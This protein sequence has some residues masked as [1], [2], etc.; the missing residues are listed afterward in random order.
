[1]YVR[2]SVRLL[3]CPSAH[4]KNSLSLKNVCSFSSLEAQ[5]D[6]KVHAITIHSRESPFIQHTSNC[7]LKELTRKSKQKS[8]KVPP[9]K[10]STLLSN[11][12]Y[13]CIFPSNDSSVFNGRPLLAIYG[14][15]DYYL[16][17][18]TNGLITVYWFKTIVVP[19][20]LSENDAKVIQIKPNNN[21]ESVLQCTTV[22]NSS[23]WSEQPLFCE[24]FNYL[25]SARESFN[26]LVI[27]ISV[28]I[29]QLSC[30]SFK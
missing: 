10:S 14:K 23:R 17:W 22:S 7:T 4:G 24:S 3:L 9:T 28:N 12:V 21:L 6:E 30:C 20:S 2:P 19:N 15:F 16:F 18:I 29:Q 1:M 13:Q 8:L 26:F 5:S 25:S 27:G 11:T